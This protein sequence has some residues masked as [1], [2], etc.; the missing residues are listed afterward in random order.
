M[1][2]LQK[3][4]IILYENKLNILNNPLPPWKDMKH[5]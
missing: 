4:L 3:A 2:Y 1:V 5:S